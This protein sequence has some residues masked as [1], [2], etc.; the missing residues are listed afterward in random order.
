MTP[1]A[2]A[3]VLE[4]FLAEYESL[5]AE[6][7]SR[8]DSQ[9]QAFQYL[10]A[11]LAAALGLYAA[12][13]EAQIDWDFVLLGLPV[14]VAPF[15]F[16]FFDN[17]LMIFRNGFYIQEHLR[18]R[19]SEI[20]GHPDVLAVENKG[21][22]CLYSSTCFVQAGVSYGRWSL[23]LLPTI[24]PPIYVLFSPGVDFHVLRYCFLLIIDLLFA[25]LLVAAVIATMRE[26]QKWKGA[27]V[28]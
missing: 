4:P 22:G 13:K 11:I 8:L 17:E 19:I 5:R 2:G 6:I 3:S 26:H 1:A 9:R 16:I 28:R 10:V 27:T 14:I 18:P 20:V 25:L 21:F 24:V 23:F 15:G 7:F 12:K